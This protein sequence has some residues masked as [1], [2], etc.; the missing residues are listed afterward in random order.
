M[1][2]LQQQRTYSLAWWLLGALLVVQLAWD[3]YCLATESR[4]VE[5]VIEDCM[6]RMPSPEAC[7]E[8]EAEA[9]EAA[10]D[11]WQAS[12][13]TKT[14]LQDR[15]PNSPPLPDSSDQGFGRRVAEFDRL[16][17]VKNAYSESAKRKRLEDAM[18]KPCG[19]ASLPM[20][21]MED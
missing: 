18:K 1:R 16:P 13:P 10:P 19:P 6:V 17:R 20:C 5:Q 21:S 4:R 3:Y 15:N 8:T 12:L 7:R 2:H 11:T 9:K 14:S